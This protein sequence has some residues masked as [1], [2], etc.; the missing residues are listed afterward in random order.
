MIV[1]FSYDLAYSF[2]SKI[3]RY[4]VCP[5]AFLNHGSVKLE[6]HMPVCDNPR[7][8]TTMFVHSSPPR[9]HGIGGG[10]GVYKF[11]RQKQGS[12]CEI[13]TNVSSISRSK[14][15]S[16]AQDTSLR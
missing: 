11:A 2:S 4:D 6:V 7:H 9:P 5:E 12:D 1:P 3:N 10:G 13:Y 8:S 15:A 16:D 14:P